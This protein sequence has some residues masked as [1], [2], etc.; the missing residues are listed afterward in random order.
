MDTRLTKER[1]YHPTTFSLTK[2]SDIPHYYG[3]Y[4]RVL[5]LA[6]AALS[7]VAIPIVGDLLP[8]GTFAQVGSAILLVLLAGLTNPHSKTILLYDTAVSG[9][10]LLLL[11]SAAISYY[12]SDSMQLFAVREVGALILMFAFYFSVKTL[13]AMS[14]KKIGKFGRPWEF[15][16]TKD[17]HE[18]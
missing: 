14:L 17:M 16:N 8:L 9:L 11:E 2:W 15:E 3:D 5:F 10:G 12:S 1:I 6:T 4:I 13:R 18:E 7:A